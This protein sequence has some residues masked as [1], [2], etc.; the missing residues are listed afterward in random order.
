VIV[1]SLSLRY[2]AWTRGPLTIYE[3]ASAGLAGSTGYIYGRNCTFSGCEEDAAFVPFP[4]LR[5]AASVGGGV[6][7]RLADLAPE[8]RMFPV[9]IHIEA[10][11]ATIGTHHGRMLSAPLLAGVTW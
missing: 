10:R 9:S 5:V 1:T 2:D 7:V 3:V 8:F 6:L 4:G 11:L